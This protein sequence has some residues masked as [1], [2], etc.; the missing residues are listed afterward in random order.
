MSGKQSAW[1]HLTISKDEISN[2]P[3]CL[4]NTHS[5][6]GLTVLVHFYRYNVPPLEQLF[7]LRGLQYRSPHLKRLVRRTAG[8]T[9]NLSHDRR[10]KTFQSERHVL[11]PLD[12]KDDYA[13]HDEFWASLGL[14]LQTKKDQPKRDQSKRSSLLCCWNN[15]R[16]MGEFKIWSWPMNRLRRAWLLLYRSEFILRTF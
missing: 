1:G 10:Y 8:Q 14:S 3:R 16:E 4:Q 2:R 15:L 7:R 12:Q 6:D 11:P 13:R 9:T 5:I